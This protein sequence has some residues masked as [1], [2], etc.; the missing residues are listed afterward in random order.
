[1]Q[2]TKTHLAMINLTSTT[3]S[4]PLAV[5]ALFHCENQPRP[6]GTQ[7]KYQETYAIGRDHGNSSEDI[8][9]VDRQRL[10]QKDVSP[11]ISACISLCLSAADRETHLNRVRKSVLRNS[12]TLMKS[13]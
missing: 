2:P 10:E 3:P 4:E 12:L 9:A 7:Y 13:H 11:N 6:K 1:M 8:Q 5:I